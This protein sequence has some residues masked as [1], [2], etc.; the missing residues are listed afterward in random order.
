M[1]KN[2]KYINTMLQLFCI[3][4]VPCVTYRFVKKIARDLIEC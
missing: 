2:V 4:N 3:E 1:N